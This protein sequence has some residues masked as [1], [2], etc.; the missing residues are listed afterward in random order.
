MGSL[1]TTTCRPF[2]LFFTHPSPAISPL[3]ND[4]DTMGSSSYSA[5]V[6]EKGHVEATS[7]QEAVRSSATFEVAAHPS[8]IA[9]P[10]T[11]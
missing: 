7:P 8:T 9:N 10:G 5:D 1:L 4:F 11:L 3:A 2:A 6:L